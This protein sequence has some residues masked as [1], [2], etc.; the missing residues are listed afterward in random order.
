MMTKKQ[1]YNLF[2]SGL[3]A[4]YSYSVQAQNSQPVQLSACPMVKICLE[5]MPDMKIPRASHTTLF[6][7]GE[8]TVIGGHTS[9]FIPTGT[10]ERLHN[11]RWDVE[12]TVYMHD[13]GFSLPLRSGKILIAGGHS[14]SL[15][16]GQTFT[17]EKYDPISHDYEGFGCL[18][19][20]RSLAQGVEL[21]GGRVVIT[22]NHYNT[23][24]IEV[25]DGKKEFAFLKSVKQ[26]RM[27]P[28][29]FR[30]AKDNAIILSAQSPRFALLD[31]IWIDRVK[32]EAF[33]VPLLNEW[34]P[35]PLDAPFYCESSFIGNE[36]KGDYSYLMPVTNKEKEI[37]MMLVRDTTFTLLSTP[38]PIPSRGIK[39]N[40]IF[41]NP[42][43]IV[44]RGAGKAYVVGYDRQNR[45]Y[46]LS[47]SLN[48]ERKETTA[49]TLY[50]TD[51]MPEVGN[52]TP[53]LTPEGDLIIAGGINFG[54][55]NYAP[56]AT[57]WK[58]HFGT[59]SAAAGK[60]ISW[61]AWGTLTLLILAVFIASIFLVLRRKK[62]EQAEPAKQMKMDDTKTEAMPLPDKSKELMK[63]ICELMEREQLF[64]NNQLRISD[65][66]IALNTNSS[67]I[68]DCINSIKGCSFN[69]FVN[70]YRIEYVKEQ[71]R[72]Y[73]NKKLTFICSE[74][75]FS[76]ETAFYRTFKTLTGMT[77]KEWH[78]KEEE[79]EQS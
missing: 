44:D 31:T 61:W 62:G 64:K 11:G 10:A 29:I 3:L 68:S 56:L 1:L 37:A 34:K 4:I 16:I 75:G 41:Y 30:T 43:P 52:A 58:L 38:C 2:F 47:I 20:K 27:N 74:A 42:A 51:P 53:L 79:H 45:L 69:Q 18:D 48:M 8:L 28:F 57:V 32:G 14:E 55:D 63:R 71:L 67:Y 25:F 12:K 36:Q 21:E 54:H 7:N 76:S 70:T 78:K 35:L 72:T 24:A 5:R 23:D 77:P 46:I 17:V 65:I 13:N 22:G 59:P 19:T 50:Y 60:G 26:E 73:P 49:L 66:A 39:G 33:T 40:G 6:V 9:G 15:G